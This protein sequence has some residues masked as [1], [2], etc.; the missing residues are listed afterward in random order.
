MVYLVPNSAGALDLLLVVVAVVLAGAYVVFMKK[1]YH[2][3]K[4]TWNLLKRNDYVCTDNSSYPGQSDR[5]SKGIAQTQNEF[6]S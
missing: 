4:N 6:G 1:Y 5:A 2:L 3:Q